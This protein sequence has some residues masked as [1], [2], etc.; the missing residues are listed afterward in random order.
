MAFHAR[1]NSTNVRMQ[2]PLDPWPVPSR[3]RCAPRIALVLWT[4]VVAGAGVEDVFARLEPEAFTALAAFAV[5]FALLSA[6]CD[7]E[8]REMLGA[9]PHK[10]ATALLLDAAIVALLGVS[11]DFSGIAWT[12]LPAAIALLVLL[13]LALV[14][15]A[16]AAWSPRVRKAAAASPGAKRAAT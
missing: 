8:V 15:H 9:S 16:A 1:R 12:A 4:L 14:L 6:W 2:S 3:A 5:A 7:A 11:R 13:P 10:L